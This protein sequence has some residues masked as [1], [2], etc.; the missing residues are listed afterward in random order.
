MPGEI[1]AGHQS[2]GL[3]RWC[4]TCCTPFET[5]GKARVCQS[6]SKTCSTKTDQCPT[7]DFP[8][9]CIYQHF[10]FLHF[11]MLSTS[12]LRYSGT[13]ALN[14]QW[15]VRCHTHALKHTHFSLFQGII[16]C[17]TFPPS[18]LFLHVASD[19]TEKEIS[20]CHVNHINGHNVTMSMKMSNTIWTSCTLGVTHLLDTLIPGSP[21]MAG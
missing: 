9:G 8:S 21:G 18:L 16:Y 19:R 2:S 13:D 4:Q 12:T 5:R 10:L 15:T 7:L 1:G 3:T 17:Q 11:H 6:A 14:M 20:K